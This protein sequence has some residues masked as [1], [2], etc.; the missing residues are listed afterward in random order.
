MPKES[1]IATSKK[2][3]Y[4]ENMQQSMY[5]EDIPVQ[6]HTQL[7]SPNNRKTTNPHTHLH[8]DLIFQ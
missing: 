6:G 8:N 4:A 3:L 5:G 1:E 2:E 7:D